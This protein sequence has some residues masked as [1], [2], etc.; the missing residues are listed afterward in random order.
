MTRPYM[1]PRPLGSSLPKAV[2]YLR[3][4]LSGSAWEREELALLELAGQHR[5]DLVKTLRIGPQVWEPVSRLLIVVRRMGAEAVVTPTLD[6]VG[7]PEEV[8]RVCHLIVGSPGLILPRL[9]SF[10]GGR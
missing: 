1:A 5:Y 6:H 9:N 4:E 10:G 3:L 8:Q 2:G 7:A